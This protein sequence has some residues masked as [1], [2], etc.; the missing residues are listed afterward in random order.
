MNEHAPSTELMN[1]VKSGLT[2]A[3]K[4]LPPF[5]FY[6]ERGSALLDRITALTE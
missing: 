6:D 3:Q 1:A 4:A 5:L 2:R